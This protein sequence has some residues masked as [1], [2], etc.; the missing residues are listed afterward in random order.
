MTPQEFAALSAQ[1]LIYLDG[2]TGTNL[3]KAGMPKGLCTESWILE[4][5]EI[6]MDLQRRYADAGSQVVYAP[7]FGANREALKK[8]GLENQVEEMNKR[9][10][11]ISQEAV[12]GR[13]FVAGDMAPTGLLLKSNGGEADDEQVFDAYA[14][15]AKALVSA[16]VDLIGLETMMSVDETTIGLDA[17]LSVTQ[18]LPIMCSLYVT[19]DGRAYYG[20]TVYEAA[21]IF[22]VQGASA[23][24]INC[25]NGPDQLEA[26]V[27]SLSR[28]TDVPVLCKPNA[29]LP[30]ID[31]KGNAV[32]DMGP[33][34]YARHMKK[35]VEA[36]AKVIGG[37][38]GTDPDYI[39][40]VRLMMEGKLITR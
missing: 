22:S 20:G 40:K 2:A 12:G 33:D 23:I 8:F 13:A 31:E 27:S 1:G 7:T 39:R 11:A 19:A 36:G 17:V 15:Q 14:E 4:N 37:C 26:I 24:G 9:L 10:V 28:L 21:E 29:G 16:G 3:Y 6:F 38:C 32:Y 18:D 5:P 30:H 25:C 34:E 35:L